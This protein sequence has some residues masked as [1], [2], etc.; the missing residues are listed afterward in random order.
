MTEHKYVRSVIIPRIFES[1]LEPVE[2][3]VEQI[4]GAV[5]IGEETIV[6]AN[7]ET[8]IGPERQ[9]IVTEALSPVRDR[10]TSGSVPHV[11]VA[12]QTDQGDVR[13]E[14]GPH[15]LEIPERKD[16]FEHLSTRGAR[17]PRGKN[18]PDHPKTH[19]TC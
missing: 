4:R 7:V 15:A 8:S 14:A 9:V 18:R 1:L 3:L 6:K 19:L 16:R 2:L 13:G 11:V 5:R 12:A 10:R 17:H